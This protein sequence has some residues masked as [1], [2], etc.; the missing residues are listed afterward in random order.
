MAP[1]KKAPAPRPSKAPI[2]RDRAFD[3]DLVDHDAD[4]AELLMEEAMAELDSFGYDEVE[5]LPASD[6]LPKATEAEAMEVDAA[7]Q[8][9]SAARREAPRV[10]AGAVRRSAHRQEAMSVDAGA[11]AQAG[12]APRKVARLERV[13]TKSMAGTCRLGRSY[14]RRKCALVD[15]AARH[16]LSLPP[17]EADLAAEAA[18]KAAAEAAAEAAAKASVEPEVGEVWIRE[19]GPGEMPTRVA[20]KKIHHEDGPPYY[21]VAMEGGG[22]LQ[23]E[24]SRLSAVPSEKASEKA[25]AK[26]SEK[27]SAEASA[28]VLTFYYGGDDGGEG[29]AAGDA[30]AGD[31]YAD[32]VIRSIHEG[33]S[34]PEA[35]GKPPVV[36]LA[37]AD[38]STVQA[39]ATAAAADAAA[40]AI[41]DDDWLPAATA[42]AEA[43]AAAATEI[44]EL[45]GGGTGWDACAARE[46]APNAADEDIREAV[47][48]FNSANEA[49]LLAVAPKLAPPP[50]YHA[51]QPDYSA[52]DGVKAAYNAIWDTYKLAAATPAP[53][54]ERVD[55]AAPWASGVE[56][57]FKLDL[58]RL[59][60]ACGDEA[61]IPLRAMRRTKGDA[62]DW[63]GPFGDELRRLASGVGPFFLR[64]A[65]AVDPLNPVTLFTPLGEDAFSACAALDLPAGAPVAAYTGELV[66]DDDEDTPASNTYLYELDMDEMRERGYEGAHG[67]QG[68]H[69]LRVDAS[70]RG[71]YAR[72]INDTWTPP[73]LPPREANVH[74]ELTYDEEAKLPMLIFYADRDLV[75]G[76]EVIVDYGP[77]YWKVT[78][79]QLQRAHS[80]AARRDRARCAE[81]EAWL[82]AEHAPLMARAGEELRHALRPVPGAPPK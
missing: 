15:F 45:A 38:S 19:P 40:A 74:V 73:G 24:R 23:T 53:G 39:A 31:E 70:R 16:G 41:L 77:D 9:G 14:H 29:G 57:C 12:S 25:S 27:V 36:A 21:T 32:A 81:L 17:D 47:T 71:G 4:N 20:I 52:F 8:A 50:F 10:D 13:Q 82:A 59:R 60:A 58:G 1:K 49:A 66:R 33:T 79:R 65:R 54:F 3:L 37:A 18:A 76:E 35:P 34:L 7:A 62:E 48:A 72:F 61:L 11:G 55:E 51:P 6:S 26:A 2:P 68:D 63:D 46:P 30:P 43:A 78:L 56:H 22:E 80:D 69:S 28:E 5:P 67:G 75:K 44:L 42:T 64:V